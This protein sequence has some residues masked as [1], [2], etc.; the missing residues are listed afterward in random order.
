MK[1][2]SNDKGKDIHI[3]WVD[4]KIQRNREIKPTKGGSINKLAENLI[5]TYI[6]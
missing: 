1:L 6:S 4:L 3:F 2:R 5:K